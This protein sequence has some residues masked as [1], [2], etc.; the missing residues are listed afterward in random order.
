MKIKRFL[1]PSMRE[2]LKAVRNEQGP[3]AVIL[4]NRRVGDYVEV[5]AALDY[6]E[7]LIQQAVKRDVPTPELQAPSISD[8][9]VVSD[10]NIEEDE[11]EE[12]TS[13]V[14]VFLNA[15]EQR[16]GASSRREKETLITD[17]DVSNSP[18]LDGIRDQLATLGDLLQEQV[19]VG[20]WDHRSHAEPVVAQMLRNLT[21]L[22]LG[23]DI[24]ESICE[25]VASRPE[26]VRHPWRDGVDMLADRLQTAPPTLLTDGGIA[27]F[28]GPTGVGKTTTIAKI[29]SQFALRHGARDIALISMDSYRIGARDQLFT[30]GRIINASVFEAD[31]PVSLR[32]L[33]QGLDDYRLVLID[34]AGVSQRDTR[35]AEMLDGLSNQSRPVDLYLTLAATA[36]EQLLDEIVRRYS[37]VS[38]KAAA[39][40]KIDEASRLG[41]PLTALARHDLPLGYVTNG[42][43]VPDDLVSAEGR[44]LWLVNQALEYAK[45]PEFEPDEQDMARRFGRK[46]VNHG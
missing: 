29:A 28:V 30:F 22:G 2:A 46:E 12:P 32:R 16:I 1:A 41:A 44:K 5:I 17:F 27:A 38:V 3:E 21:R 37:Q 10:V 15:Q 26:G 11:A 9:D 33:L 25:S 42:Q 24:A 13:D 45:A 39:I 8:D 18:E 31:S 7:A 34:T 19:S 6:D 35:L 36:D 43:R 23:N 14:H 20:R 4:S 40:T